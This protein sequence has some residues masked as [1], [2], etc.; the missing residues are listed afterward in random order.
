MKRLV[1]TLVAMLTLVS[2]TACPDKGGNGDQF[3]TAENSCFNYARN[4]QTGQYYPL[5]G[6]NPAYPA[7][8]YPPGAYPPGAYPPGAYPPGAVPGQPINCN[9]G[10]FAN[11]NGMI[12]PYNTIYN[13]Q[14][15]TGCSIYSTYYPGTI[16]Y[17]VNIQGYGYVCVK[18]QYF[19]SLP[20][21]G[22]YQ[23]Y[24]GGFPTY[25]RTCQTGVNCGGCYGGAGAGSVSAGVSTGGFWLGG[26]L[27]LCY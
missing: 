8:A 15:M 17:P 7:G 5:P 3:V 9:Q 1:M 26:T 12:V 16:Y 22:A 2:L 14:Y 23:Q 4:M 18:Q 20:G 11:Y 13:G 21:F 27:G 24:Y 25:A 19:Y 6:T 10:Q